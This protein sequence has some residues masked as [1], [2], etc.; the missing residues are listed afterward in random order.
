MAAA[1]GGGSEHRRIVGLR[2]HFVAFALIML[3]ALVVALA[4]DPGAAG[5]LVLPLVGWGSVL[6]LHVAWVMGLLDILRPSGRGRHDGE[7]GA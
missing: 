2:I 3:V 1:S 4:V 5:W 6:A 7:R